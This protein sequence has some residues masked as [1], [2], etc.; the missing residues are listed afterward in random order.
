VPGTA[1]AAPQVHKLT[2]E[3]LSAWLDGVVPTL[4]DRD[5]LSGATVVVVHGSQVLALRGYGASD[6]ARAVPGVAPVDPVRQ[7]FRAGSVSKVFT[8]TAVMQQ[9]QQGRLDLD[10]DV[11]RYLDFPLELPKGR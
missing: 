7:L 2:R 5:A 6:R 10:T 3:D 1:R 8:A 4:L 9:V 11:R